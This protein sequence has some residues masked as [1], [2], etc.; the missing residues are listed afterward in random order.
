MRL[1]RP[2][3]HTDHFEITTG[4][5][6]FF[7]RGFAKGSRLM[8]A[9]TY[10]FE[11]I[12]RRRRRRGGSEPEVNLWSEPSGEAAKHSTKREVTHIVHKRNTGRQEEESKPKERKLS[13]E[14][15]VL[16]TGLQ[17]RHCPE[18]AFLLILPLR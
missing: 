18:V 5:H 1:R 14:D 12:R 3:S 7:H 15:D 8:G 6:L 11:E 17:H 10:L 16:V 9:D 13:G 2:L 4:S